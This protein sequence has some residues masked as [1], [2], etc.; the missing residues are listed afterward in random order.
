MS[1]VGPDRCALVERLEQAFDRVA[2]RREPQLISLEAPQGWGKTRIVQVF[3]ER[4]AVRQP[5]PAYWPPALVAPD[6]P[7]WLKV[8]K[9]VAP[10][11]FRRGAD[12]PWMW[13][14][15][16]CGQS[17][18]HELENVLARD[19]GHLDLHFTG[20]LAA[21]ADRERLKR[22]V[23]AVSKSAVGLGLDVLQADTVLQA[24]ELAVD[25]SR[26][27]VHAARR[28][29][30]ER[31][32]DEVQV[33]QAV[34][35]GR[36]PLVEKVVEV[37]RRT[38]GD[39][40]PFVIVVDDA[41]D[42]DESVIA[43][44]EHIF[45]GPTPVP[46]L[47]VLTA[48]PDRLAKQSRNREGLG[49]WLEH[50][51]ERD[52]ARCQR[53]LLARLK[54]GELASI[55]RERA[56]ATEAV[57]ASAFA[58]RADGNPLVLEGL[59]QLPRVIQAIRNGGIALAAEEVRDFD[60]K[61]PTIMRAAWEGLPLPVR[62]ALCLCTLQGR[63]AVE[64]LLLDSYAVVVPESAPHA[65]QALNEAV[66]PYAWI[67]REKELLRFRERHT[68]EIAR[69]SLTDHL[70]REAVSSGRRSIVTRIAGWRR[71]RSTWEDLTPETRRAL[72]RIHVE[73]AR[74]GET[75][76]LAAAAASAHEL[77][78]GALDA[79]KYAQARGLA[80]DALAW[81]QGGSEEVY[82]L[83]LGLQLVQARAYWALGE[84]DRGR[85]LLERVLTE[86]EASLS[87]D[88]PL[89]LEARTVLARVLGEGGDW[90]RARE[91]LERLVE[92]SAR[93]MG[94]DHDNTLDARAHLAVA[95][96]YGGDFGEAQRL[97]AELLPDRER[98][99]SPRHPDAV[100]VRLLLANLKMLDEPER[101]REIQEE[102]VRV[103]E[104]ALG[105]D[106]PH[107]LEARSTLALT[108]RDLGYYRE[109]RALQAQ[110]IEDC[111]RILGARHQTTLGE[112]VHLAQTRVLAGDPSGTSMQRAAAADL[113][114]A[115]GPN[116]P[117]TLAAR[118]K[119]AETMAA[120]GDVRSA[121]L[122]LGRLLGEVEDRL[123]ARH[124]ET[125]A[126]RRALAG[127]LLS[128]SDGG[129]EDALHYARE[130]LETEVAERKRSLGPRHH[131]S[132]GASADLA[133]ARFA[134]GEE[135]AARKILSD[136]TEGLEQAL[137]SD[138]RETLAA[139]QLAGDVLFEAG[140]RDDALAIY[141][142][143]L[144]ARRRRLGSEHPDVIDALLRYSHA[145]ESKAPLDA[146]VLNEEAYQAATRTYGQSHPVTSEALRRV[147]DV[148]LALGDRERAC[149]AFRRLS[150]IREQV[151]GADHL[152]T[153]RA[154]YWLAESLMHLGESD[155]AKRMMEAVAEAFGQVAE[156]AEEELGREHPY[157]VSV[158]GELAHI[159][160][161]LGRTNEAREAAPVVGGNL[162]ASL[163]RGSYSMERLILRPPDRLAEVTAET[164]FLPPGTIDVP[165]R[166]QRA[167]ALQAVSFVLAFALGA[168]TAVIAPTGVA[169]F[170]LLVPA[171]LLWWLAATN[172]L[173]VLFALNVTPARYARARGEEL[174]DSVDGYTELALEP[175]LLPDGSTA[176]R[177]RFEAVRDGGSQMAHT[178]I[179]SALGST[180][181]SIGTSVAVRFAEDRVSQLDRT[182]EGISFTRPGLSARARRHFLRQLGRGRARGAIRARLPLGWLH[183]ESLTVGQ[184]DGK[185]NVIASVE[186]IDPAVDSEEFAA[187]QGQFLI[188][189]FSGYEEELFE[190]A[191]V[192][193]HQSGYL[194]AFSW[195]PDD[196]Q[197][198]FQWQ[199]Y[200]ADGGRGYTATATCLRRDEARYRKAL[201]KRL[202]E[203]E[204][205]GQFATE[206]GTFPAQAEHVVPASA[207]GRRRGRQR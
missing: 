54:P 129:T 166:R 106:H 154:R 175:L 113:E 145:L 68:F 204:I 41:H 126:T 50:A 151:L 165:A 121:H 105:A 24:G 118:R 20:L 59:L 3:Y 102:A 81:T 144:E 135:E 189:E 55:V 110:T 14:G 76:D 64:R 45:A 191:Q 201:R 141:N 58:D 109:A 119:M 170:P 198:V 142:E 2:E 197:P 159:L 46:V 34:D 182:V 161:T 78:L 30:G 136:V 95:I 199:A 100:E 190:P 62:E 88:H 10:E 196:G 122:T 75:G 206:G 115:L 187:L 71:E 35:P 169:V 130:L 200:F 7:G 18:T 168:G 16:R 72:R 5:E 44:L 172:V 193:S 202:E 28:R 43:V 139:R 51:V 61:L 67:H 70:S 125:G 66:D 9:R 52:P 152:E 89:A 57:V 69:G 92:D 186:S 15:L 101:A 148:A 103:A 32:D 155:D 22:D 127:V 116:H 79:G 56:P 203:I 108:L 112:R 53:H 174:A 13:W 38:A 25:V 132:V 133:L 140:D 99:F 83:R 149:H 171:V 180:V 185:A 29:G 60:N 104:E 128:T 40:L 156:R 8:R 124:P 21:Q 164:R 160:E 1:F 33:V 107:V 37:I 143:V 131:L 27:V 195:R 120:Q 183:E 137:G 157:T 65:K 96:L 74:A 178:E 179:Y 19:V 12:M 26:L 47:C 123:G 11:T 23:A 42:A 73:I 98:A 4:L 173:P 17:E 90:R 6:E 31:E 91:M 162:S 77:G 147:A 181:L 177:R 163:P 153:L 176:L 207:S 134:T 138:A 158:Q 63:E 80:E 205:K 87:A 194:R 94:R 167:I 86:A 188:D 111:E 85:K 184:I 117:D 146:N 49:G 114:Q 150:A 39:G 36:A 82:E 97:L 48:W 192:F 93:V 84:P